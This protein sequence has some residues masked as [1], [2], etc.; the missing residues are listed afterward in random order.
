MLQSYA[1]NTEMHHTFS[2]CWGWMGK[3][4]TENTEDAVFG[5]GEYS[6]WNEK[7]IFVWAYTTTPRQ[8]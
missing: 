2:E 7:E 3:C 6:A 5:G 1:W 8:Q 4:R